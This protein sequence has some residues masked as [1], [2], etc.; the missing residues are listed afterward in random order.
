MDNFPHL[1]TLVLVAAAVVVLIF[2]LNKFLFGPLNEILAKRQAEVEE[3]R[4]AFDDATRQQDARLQQ[5]EQRL[6]DARKESFV[7]R[8]REQ[9]EGKRLREA[10]LSAARADAAAAVEQA[11]A[12]LQAEVDVAKQQL[13]HQ[14]DEI[15][16][17]VAERL[18]DRPVGAGQGSS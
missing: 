14:A 11:K 17:K 10:E 15:A 3:A 1:P 4:A 16:R 5:V 6:A 13:E 2:I 12:E 8:E 9:A 7:L 18:L